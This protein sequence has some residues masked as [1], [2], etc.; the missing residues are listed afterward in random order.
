MSEARY[1][2]ARINALERDLAVQDLRGLDLA[3]TRP[4]YYDELASA[5]LRRSYASELAYKDAVLDLEKS[6][7]ETELA[8]ERERLVAEAE[9]A[10][11]LKK[12]RQEE[13]HLRLAD[14]KCHLRHLQPK[15]HR[16]AAC[17][18]WEG[19][20]ETILK[21]SLEEEQKAKD[22]QRSER[23]L[24]RVFAREQAE[25]DACRALSDARWRDLRRSRDKLEVAAA[26][27]NKLR[28]VD[29]QL[30]RLRSDLH[31]QVLQDQLRL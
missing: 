3:L 27:E 18:P 17:N 15:H 4:L 9:L 24:A 13:M 11:E 2:R 6:R 26:S 8:L 28:Y 16:C 12:V 1:L 21:R 20:G 19:Y 29:M 5:R 23:N 14:V 22:R 25:R 30:N 10:A 7:L 31:A